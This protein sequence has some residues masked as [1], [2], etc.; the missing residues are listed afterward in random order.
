MQTA[1]QPGLASVSREAL[2]QGPGSAAFR[3]LP[4]G[5]ALAGAPFGEAWRALRGAGA[6]LV[7][8]VRCGDG[9]VL[10]NPPQRHA[11]SEG[12]ELVA[13]ARRGGAPFLRTPFV[14][15]LF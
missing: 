10:L 7:G 1:L 5:P 11:L 3:Y 13:L 12:D 6:W 14:R 4:V 2:R 15:A 9:A 8:V